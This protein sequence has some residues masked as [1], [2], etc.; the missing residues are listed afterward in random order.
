MVVSENFHERRKK[1]L[2]ACKSSEDLLHESLRYYLRQSNNGVDENT[3]LADKFK[4]AV[5][6]NPSVVK[7]I[8]S[9]S[10][11]CNDCKIFEIGSSRNKVVSKNT[12][13]ILQLYNPKGD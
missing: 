6:H 3:T 1:L 12:K 8:G 7:K 2:I 4:Y 5:K 13:L 11:P 9:L 10:Y